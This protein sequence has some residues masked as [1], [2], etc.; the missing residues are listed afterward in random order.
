MSS[1]VVI[2]NPLVLFVDDRW[3]VRVVGKVQ[4]M[5][6]RK[7]T[8]VAAAVVAKRRV[9][10]RAKA[11]AM[12]AVRIVPIVARRMVIKMEIGEE[13]SCRRKARDGHGRSDMPF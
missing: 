2:F 4:V 8:I 3:R 10:R 13:P 12:T 1:F 5:E 7:E 11:V 6:T 9:R